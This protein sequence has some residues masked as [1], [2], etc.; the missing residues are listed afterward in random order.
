[1]H[2]CTKACTSLIFW[3]VSKVMLFNEGTYGTPIEV[4][5]KFNCSIHSLKCHTVCQQQKMTYK[6]KIEFP[7]KPANARISNRWSKFA[8]YWLGFVTILSFLF[9]LLTLPPNKVVI[10]MTWTVVIL[11]DPFERS[12]GKFSQQI[13]MIINWRK[14]MLSSIL[15]TASAH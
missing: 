3:R 1:M 8:T 2:W 13:V 10:E 12:I 14:H 9:H 4:W 5:I 15:I 11:S 7:L 6:I